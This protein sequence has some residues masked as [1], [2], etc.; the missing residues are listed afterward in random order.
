M[1]DST[2]HLLLGRA[3]VCV[4]REATLNL[5]RGWL[6]EMGSFFKKDITPTQIGQEIPQGNLRRFSEFSGRA[7]GLSRVLSTLS[8]Q[9]AS[10]VLALGILPPLLSILR[11]HA[12]WVSIIS[13]LDRIKDS[14]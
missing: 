13:N 8:Q 2:I 14:R 7:V 3:C 6:K 11:V 9:H 1:S 12:V 5:M 10:S 4:D